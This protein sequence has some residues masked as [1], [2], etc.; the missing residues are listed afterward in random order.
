MWVT[1][2]TS[3]TRE[4]IAEQKETP[5]AERRRKAEE[6]RQRQYREGVEKHYASATDKHGQG[7][8][9]KGMY[10]GPDREWHEPGA[11]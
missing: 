3:R 11:W 1:R 6:E 2:D 5:E 8:P 4:K 10:L 9:K 7:Q